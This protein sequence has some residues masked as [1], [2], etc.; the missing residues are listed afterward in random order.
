[1]RGAAVTRHVAILARARRS[2]RI[3]VRIRRRRLTPFPRPGG[4]GRLRR[5]GRAIV[6]IDEGLESRDELVLVLDHALHKRHAG[7]GRVELVQGLIVL[8][9]RDSN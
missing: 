6:G 4:E 9:L 5:A 8:R 7:L 1:L 2:S 3:R